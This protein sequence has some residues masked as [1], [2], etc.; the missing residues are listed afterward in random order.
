MCKIV[1]DNLNDKE[2]LSVL[3][4]FL[5]VQNGGVRVTLVVGNGRNE[6]EYKTSYSIE[7]SEEMFDEIT[8][9]PC[10]QSC[11]LI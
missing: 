5:K 11:R 4:D 8:K 3:K 1:L 6:R 7:D 10:V 2:S 9:F